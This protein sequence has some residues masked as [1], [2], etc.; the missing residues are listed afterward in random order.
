M[1]IKPNVIILQTPVSKMGNVSIKDIPI[2]TTNLNGNDSDYI[3]TIRSQPLPNNIETLTSSSLNEDIRQMVKLLGAYCKTRSIEEIK[4]VISSIHSTLPT[5]GV[6]NV[7]NWVK[8][9][10]GLHPETDNF[11]ET[12]PYWKTPYSEVIGT[13][14]IMYYADNSTIDITMWTSDPMFV[15]NEIVWFTDPWKTVSYLRESVREKLNS[16]VVDLIQRAGNTTTSL[17][18]RNLV[19]EALKTTAEGIGAEE[20]QV[21]P[22]PANLA[23]GISLNNDWYNQTNRIMPSDKSA[24]R[25]DAI[26]RLDTGGVLIHVLVNHL[27]PLVPKAESIKGAIISSSPLGVEETFPHR[28]DIPV[29][30]DIGGNNLTENKT[31]VDN[32]V[33]KPEKE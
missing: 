4:K 30:T 9:L 3:D 25:N 28:I 18:C 31:V 33:L 19:R 2:V 12:L 29:K 17:M 23:H 7:K 21:R 10:T 16:E 11:L 13:N 27:K 14:T 5:K 22:I 1:S 24:A 15:T 26:T 32:S 20:Y 8:L 6:S